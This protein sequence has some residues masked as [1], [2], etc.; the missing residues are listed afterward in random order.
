MSID[1]NPHDIKGERREMSSIS[2]AA[3]SIANLLSYVLHS[4]AHFR[5][6]RQ[7]ANLRIPHILGRWQKF[8]RDFIFRQILHFSC[9]YMIVAKLSV[10]DSVHDR[11]KLRQYAA[12]VY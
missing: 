1:T 12:S 6:A 4:T 5:A 2:N 7:R 11:V 10:H 9:Q 3:N 8:R